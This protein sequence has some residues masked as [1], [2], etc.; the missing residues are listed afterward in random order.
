MSDH[1]PNTLDLYGQDLWVSVKDQRASV[2]YT[3]VHASDSS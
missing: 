3:Q 1:N 2:Q